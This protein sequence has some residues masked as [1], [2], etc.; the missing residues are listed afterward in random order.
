AVPGSVPAAR[1]IGDKL[2]RLR[3]LEVKQSTRLSRRGHELSLLLTQAVIAAQVTAAPPSPP[4]LAP[5]ERKQVPPAAP[6]RILAHSHTV[7]PRLPRRTL[8][9][10]RLHKSEGSFVDSSVQHGIVSLPH[11]V[12]VASCS[13]QQFS[14]L[15]MPADTGPE[16]C[17]GAVLSC[18]VRVRPV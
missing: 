8:P 13:D 6:L 7:I 16:Q 15:L 2:F 3:A 4:T 18:C 17:A 10:E 5:Q 9:D 11:C 14:Q 1:A 12:D